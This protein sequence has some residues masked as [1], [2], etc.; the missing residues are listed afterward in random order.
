MAYSQIH[1]YSPIQKNFYLLPVSPFDA[2]H[3][4]IFAIP[5]GNSE[6]YDYHQ[7]VEDKRHYTPFHHPSVPPSPPLLTTSS[8]NLEICEGKKAHLTANSN[9]II[10]WYTTP[11]PLGTPVGTGTSYITPA[12][13]AGYYTYY[14]VAEHNGIKSDA[15][16]MEVVMVYPEP[17]ITISSN[18]TSA[19]ALESITLTASGTTYYEWDNGVVADYIVIQPARTQTFK[20]TGVNTAGCRTTSEFTQAVKTCD[21]ANSST[22]SAGYAVSEVKEYSFRVYPNPNHGE[23]NLNLSSL[24]E[25]V[26]VEIYNWFGGLVYSNK[27]TSPLSNIQL[28]DTQKGIYILRIIENET[29][30][31]QE[32]V[33]VD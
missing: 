4:D 10:Y 33:L 17:V 2:E 20:V 3:T 26:R 27:V 5:T 19:C 31:H 22:Q 32:K 13:T 28:R 11:P 7:E 25:T 15:T 1:S 18:M 6:N 24:S 23:F 30:I 16:A 8:E 14:A 21:A 29:L 9:H 12:L